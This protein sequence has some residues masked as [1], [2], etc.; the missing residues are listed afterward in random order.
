MI[1]ELTMNKGKPLMWEK[2]AKPL[3][4]IQRNKAMDFKVGDR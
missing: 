3:S 1:S 4:R 2:N